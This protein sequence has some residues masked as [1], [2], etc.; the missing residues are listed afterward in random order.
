MFGW[1]DL[2]VLGGIIGVNLVMSGDNAV[3]IA[4]ASQRLPQHMRRKVMF[5]GSLAA[6]I[7]RVL[8]TGVAVS[9]LKMPYLQ[10]IGGTVLVWIAYKL[11]ADSQEAGDCKEANG[12]LEAV[13][14]ILIADLIMSVDNVLA[15]A[16]IA[17]TSEHEYLF[18]I[19]GLAMSLPLVM[20][21]A[22]MVSRLLE[23]YP[24]LIYGGAGILLYAAG[25]LIL[26]DVSLQGFGLHAYSAWF[27]A[28]LVG[29]TLALGYWKNAQAA[30]ETEPEL[31]PVRID[32][33][34]N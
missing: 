18:L 10:L 6:V 1:N 14:I 16:A 33:D 12:L 13:K 26:S 11:M 31:I 2:A 29:G 34:E 3:I 25:E 4:L 22:E 20:F 5:W 15:L 24:V 30:G 7:L 27:E 17:R 28:T 8:A 21:G 19:L 32:E 23:R 9:L